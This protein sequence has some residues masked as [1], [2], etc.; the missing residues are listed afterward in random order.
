MTYLA[1]LF[2]AKILI[3]LGLLVWPF[4]G[5]P[6]AK[7]EKAF[8]VSAARA[9]LF[10]LYGVALLAL[11]IGYSGGLMQALRGTF[12]LEILLMA[13]VSNIGAVIALITTGAAKSARLYVYL[14]GG[15]GAAFCGVLVS[16]FI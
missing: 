15:F 4:L 1:A 14:F 2:G 9:T 7:L 6:K 8:G 11:L 16:H 3:S 12:A 5:W 13:A 10:R